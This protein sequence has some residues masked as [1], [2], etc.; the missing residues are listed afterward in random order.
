LSP[1]RVWFHRALDAECTCFQVNRTPSERA[2]L[3]AAQPGPNG[4]S[5]DRR[6]PM[7]GQFHKNL[8]DLVG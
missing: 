2:N 8:A 5:G 4:D 6:Q 3:A 1:A 7:P